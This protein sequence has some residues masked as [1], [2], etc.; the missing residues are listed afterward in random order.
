MGM[1]ACI[2]L[3]ETLNLSMKDENQICKPQ[4]EDSLDRV[5]KLIFKASLTF[6][7]GFVAYTN[8][9]KNLQIFAQRTII[10]FPFIMDISWLSHIL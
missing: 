6:I 4:I 9:Q 10:Y 2:H 1:G 7:L 8:L 5:F 3:Q